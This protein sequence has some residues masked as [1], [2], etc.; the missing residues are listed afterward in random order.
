MKPIRWTVSA[1]LVLAGCGRQDA[2]SPL[3]PEVSL[4]ASKSVAQQGMVLTMSNA[5][6]GNSVH[7][8]Y[9]SSDGSLSAGPVY[10]TGGTGSGG[11]LG[12]QGALFYG[13]RFIFVVNAGSNDISTF[14]VRRDGLEFVGVTPSGGVRPVSVTVRGD[15]LYVLNGGG[16]NNIAG[17]SVDADGNL[18]PL[19]GSVRGLSA[20]T[21]A[22]AQVEFSPSG[23]VLVV[24]EKATNKISTYLVD[25]GGLTTGPIV[26]SSVGATPFGF[27]FD[28]RGLLIVSEAF[29]GA[30]DASAAS[31]YILQNNGLLSVRSASVPTTE[32]AACWFVV[33]NSGR[34]AYTTNTGSGSISGYRVSHD[35]TLTLIAADGL[36]GVT[37]PG[38]A[39]T[40][41]A[42]SRN[43][44]YLFVL[45]SGNGTIGS[46]S[47]RADGSL[48][49]L[50]SIGGLPLSAV[51]MAAE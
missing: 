31:S 15:L 4:S 17:F 3:G 45:N 19:A 33:T 25:G 18:T 5:A 38:S 20:G 46:F 8:F 16:T 40:D 24:T 35:G 51:G 50:S 13:G 29:G 11:G 34:F 49:P 14:A 21:T 10:P 32:T 39:P 12:S 28:R 23:R 42:L 37:G 26:N 30:P 9:R 2:A 1:A 48:T 36:T 6:S 43:S 41:L 7:V 47:V 27:A 22:P 44:R